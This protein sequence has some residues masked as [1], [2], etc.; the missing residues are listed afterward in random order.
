[1]QQLAI[2]LLISSSAA[3]LPSA[4]KANGLAL[5][6]APLFRSV[7]TP[8]TAGGAL[9]AMLPRGLACCADDLPDDSFAVGFAPGRGDRPLQLSLG[10]IVA[11]EAQLPSSVNLINKNRARRSSFIKDKF[12]ST[13]WRTVNA[14]DA[15]LA[16]VVCEIETVRRVH[17]CSVRWDQCVWSVYGS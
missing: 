17:M 14:F 10:D 3:S 7:A 9:L 16:C 6:A 1:M 15:S 2:F 13:C 8:S 4:P 12:E 5:G 11:D